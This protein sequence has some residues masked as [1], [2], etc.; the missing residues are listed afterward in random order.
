MGKLKHSLAGVP[1]GILGAGA[2]LTSFAHGFKDGMFHTFDP[3]SLIRD[4]TP[5]ALSSLGAGYYFGRDEI[6]DIVKKKAEVY[7]KLGKKLDT[8]KEYERILKEST[9]K[10]MG[11][12][13]GYTAFAYGI[14]WIIGS[15]GIR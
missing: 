2:I 13:F 6:R 14:G 5:W 12:L 1:A 11:E 7:E 3:Y 9:L 8:E 4:V 15:L 10:S